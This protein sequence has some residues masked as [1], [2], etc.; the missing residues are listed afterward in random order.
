MS[1]RLM[2][3]VW[4]RSDINATQKLVLLALADW[5]NDEGLCWPSIAKLAVKSSLTARC[6]QK[7][8]R[9]LEELGFIKRDEVI[10]KGNRY[11]IAIPLNEVHPCTTFT[12]PL[13]DVHPTPEPGSP[14][15]SITHQSNTNV[16][17][18][19]PDWLPIDAWEG[20]LAM[21]KKLKK[22]A[23]E[24]AMQ[25]A[26]KKLQDLAGQGN[27]PAAVLDQSTMAGWTDLYPIK[28][29]MSKNGKRNYTA[30]SDDGLSS[31][32]RAALSVFGDDGSD[33]EPYAS[34]QSR[35]SQ[36]TYGLPDFNSAQ[37]HDGGSQ[38][39]L[40]ASGMDDAEPFAF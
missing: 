3:S 8:I 30:K 32:A 40:A 14:N 12:P 5:A 7:A 33:Y 17:I 6:V 2:T 18:G 34:D 22:P 36:P 21:R 25:M 1:I 35:V 26:I 31:T 23:T 16:I 37:R 11:W 38:I 39:R 27:D 28:R 24:R 4:E 19:L 9:S 15:T 13:N 10:G 20:W 29:D